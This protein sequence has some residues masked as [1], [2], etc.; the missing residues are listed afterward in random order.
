[1]SAEK[2]PKTASIWRL[3][4]SGLVPVWHHGPPQ[5]TLKN[6]KE[7]RKEAECDAEEGGKKIK[8]EGLPIETGPARIRGEAGLLGDVHTTQLSLCSCFATVE[9]SQASW[10]PISLPVL[11]W[12]NW[13]RLQ[14]SGVV[15]DGAK[16][17]YEVRFS[18]A[19]K[20]CQRES[21]L[22][23][24]GVLPS[25]SSWVTSSPWYFLKKQTKN[26]NYSS[27]MV[28][29]AIPRLFLSKNLNSTNSVTSTFLTV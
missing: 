15:G 14:F 29:H 7:N 16:L 17:F 4:A 25:I 26:K 9:P 28:K 19:I 27:K 8:K 1:M 13:S 11:N 10:C 12:A 24:P 6:N 5:K 22:S 3:A 21:K 23:N 18:A 20:K 2:S